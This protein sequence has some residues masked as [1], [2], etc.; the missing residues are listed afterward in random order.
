MVE[1][2][3]AP[4]EPGLVLVEEWH[5]ELWGPEGLSEEQ[6]A[7]LRQTIDGELTEWVTHVM[8]G[9]LLSSAAELRLER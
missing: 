2:T 7:E 5:L 8:R 6:V 3:R 4:A 9:L 1:D